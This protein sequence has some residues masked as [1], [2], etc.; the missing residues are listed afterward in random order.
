MLLLALTTSCQL[1]ADDEEGVGDDGYTAATRDA[2][3]ALSPPTGLTAIPSDGAAV[4]SWAPAPGATGY[5][6]YHGST[7]VL[8]VADAAATVTTPSALVPGL[9]NGTA[10]WF[11]VAATKSGIATARSAVVCAVPTASDLTG[12]TLHDSLCAGGLDGAKW[13]STGALGGAY[14]V[15]V[16]NGAAVIGQSMRN[17]EA[18]GQRGIV[19]NARPVVGVTPGNRVTKLAADVVVPAGMAEVTGGSIAFAGV[20]LIYQPPTRRLAFPGANQDLLFVESGLLV[21]AAGIQAYR[22]VGHCDDASCVTSTNT[23]VKITDPAGWTASGNRATSSAAYDTTYRVSVELD[24]SSGEL[25]FEISGGSFGAA[26]V[27]GT[28]NP[29]VYV[30]VTPGWAGITPA[31]GGFFVAQFGT[32]SFDGSSTGGGSGAITARFDNV[33]VAVNSGTPSAWDDFSG[34]GANSGPSGLSLSKW[35]SG[36]ANEIDASPG[37]LTLRQRAPAGAPA[38]PLNPL[39]VAEPVKIHVIQLDVSGLSVV[40]ALPRLLV[41]G[42]FYNDGFAGTTAPDVNSQNSAVGDILAGVTLVPG[43]APAAQYTVIRCKTA[44]CTGAFDPIASGPIGS[45]T[46][47][48]GAIHPVRLAWDPSTRLFTFSVDAQSI[49]VDPTATA[50]VHDVFPHAPLIR[51][52]TVPVASNVSETPSIEASVT[53]VFTAP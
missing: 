45:G 47:G 14:H 5:V 35:G 10:R 50:P 39:F 37:K 3:V 20:R 38:A 16:A 19:Y 25:K 42:R 32:A 27:S 7:P 18:R 15:G 51:I 41:Q 33:E 31:S 49:D 44:N 11:A 9:T 24:E 22:Q 40:G 34:T 1:P 52:S 46:L 23:G 30:G 26:G 29:G 48:R 36:G 17:Q 12:L 21:D 4:L 28:A 8:T 6:V 2:A 43:S 53:N 13:M